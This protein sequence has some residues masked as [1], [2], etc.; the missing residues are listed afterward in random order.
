MSEDPKKYISCSFCGL[1]RDQVNK[2]IAGP[3][4]Y[5]CDECVYLCCE[6]VGSPEQRRQE[7]RD[8]VD[9]YFKKL[10]KACEEDGDSSCAISIAGYHAARHVFGKDLDK[11]FKNDLENHPLPP[12]PW[13]PK[14]KPKAAAT[15]PDASPFGIGS[16]L[17]VWMMAAV[18]GGG[19]VM[20]SHVSR[21]IRKEEHERGK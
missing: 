13:P 3:G 10:A 5:I 9:V 16:S 12:W 2:I 15:R 1:A 11:A 6:I 18:A 4:C 8:K 19:A 14:S 7:L 17:P 20:A 21:A